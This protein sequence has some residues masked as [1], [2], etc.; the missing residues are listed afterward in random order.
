PT[1]NARGVS[2]ID[3]AHQLLAT[4]TG[5]HQAHQFRAR[6]LDGETRRERGG[7]VEI[8]YAACFPVG[9]KQF[10]N[11]VAVPRSHRLKYAPGGERAKGKVCRLRVAHASRVLVSASRRN[12]LF[13]ESRCFGMTRS[14]NKSSRS[15]GR[16]RQHARRVRYPGRKRA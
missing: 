10:L 7:D 3:G 9:V 6:R 16:A 8:I 12:R 4:K 1:A 14:H 11:R 15:R 13:L 2:E 5:K